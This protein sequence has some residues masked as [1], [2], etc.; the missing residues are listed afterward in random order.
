MSLVNYKTAALIEQ[1]T[2]IKASTIKRMRLDGKLKD[3]RA[4][5]SNSRFLY[6]TDEVL[7]QY[8]PYDATKKEKVA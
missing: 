7:R 1:E 8:A 4:N 5:E 6:N 3:V 2:G